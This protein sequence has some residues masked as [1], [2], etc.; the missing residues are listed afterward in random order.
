VSLRFSYI[1]GP[2]SYHK[3]SVIAK[4]FRQV[5]ARQTL[6]VFGE[7][8]Q[9]RDFLFVEDLCQAIMAAMTTELP[10]GEPIQLGTGK[11]TSVNTLVTLMRQ[12]APRSDMSRR[13]RGR[14][15]VT[16]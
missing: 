8:G 3:G 10:F 5:Q 15:C 14:S 6:T 2:F 4:F 13:G 12:V 1:Y 7:G 16:S 11:E 9:T